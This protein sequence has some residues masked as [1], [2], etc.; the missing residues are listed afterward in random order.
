MLSGAPLAQ[1]SSFDCHATE[2]CSVAELEAIFA[3]APSLGPVNFT[4]DDA[5]ASSVTV[6][7]FETNPATM[8]ATRGNDTALLFIQPSGSGAKY[9]GQT[10]TFWEHQGEALITWGHDTKAMRCIKPE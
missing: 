2:P 3:L 1:E 10:V 7:F 5:G 8:L 4:C 9:Q 6:V